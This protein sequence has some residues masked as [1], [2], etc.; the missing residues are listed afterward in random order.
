MITLQEFCDLAK[1]WDKWAERRDRQM[2][3][4]YEIND[5]SYE[6]LYAEKACLERCAAEL[7][8]VI[9]QMWWRHHEQ[10]IRNLERT[11]GDAPETKISK[12]DLR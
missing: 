9:K 7:R 5:I 1:E 3:Q 11:Y 8:A 10:N 6:R 4:T 12:G 2:N